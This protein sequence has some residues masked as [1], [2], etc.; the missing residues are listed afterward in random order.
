MPYRMKKLKDFGQPKVKNFGLP[1][2]GFAG[3]VK[4]IDTMQ[5]G[6]IRPLAHPL[7]YSRKKL[8]GY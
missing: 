5:H 2:G 1:H 6:H 7:G 8:G 4:A 3:S